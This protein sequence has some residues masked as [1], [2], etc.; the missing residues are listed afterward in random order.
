MSCLCQE[1]SMVSS[2]LRTTRLRI[3]FNV[4]GCAFE[5]SPKA[6]KTI[7]PRMLI[8]YSLTPTSTHPKQHQHQ[9]RTKKTKTPHNSK[10]GHQLQKKLTQKHENNITQKHRKKKQRITQKHWTLNDGSPKI[11]GNQHVQHIIPKTIPKISNNPH[12]PKK[13]ST[14]QNKH[15]GHPGTAQ[16]TALLQDLSSHVQRKILRVHHTTDEGQPARHQVLVQGDTGRWW[17]SQG[18]STGY[19]WFGDWISMGFLSF[20]CGFLDFVLWISMGSG[21]FLCVS[22][23]FDVFFFLILFER[24]SLRL[25]HFNGP[26]INMIRNDLWMQMYITYKSVCVWDR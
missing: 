17:R 24:V 1:S 23:G 7:C 12:H 19:G 14:K 11:T 21:W 20:F 26:L 4:P 22:V 15:Q 2:T 10:S 6:L 13:T 8:S 3:I 25:L 16:G 5:A 18:N 9:E